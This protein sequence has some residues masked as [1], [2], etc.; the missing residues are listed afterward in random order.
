[1]YATYA[2]GHEMKLICNIDGVP[3]YTSSNLQFWAI[4]CSVDNLEPF[5]NA[6]V[7][8]N[9][10]PN[11][12]D[13]YLSDLVSELLNLCEDGI[14]INDEVVDIQIKAFVCDAPARAFLKCIK[15][16]TGYHSCERCRVTHPL[17]EDVYFIRKAASIYGD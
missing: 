3:V 16:H 2:V 9:S 6:I 10:K 7:Y 13:D 5:I 8:G 12:V 11:S 17:P 15:G 4:L 14:H 1:M